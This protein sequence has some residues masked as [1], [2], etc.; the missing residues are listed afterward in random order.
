MSLRHPRTVALSLCTVAVVAVGAWRYVFHR[1]VPTYVVVLDA[2]E[3][4]SHRCDAVLGVVDQFVHRAEQSGAHL[5]LVRT[6]DDKTADEPVQYFDAGLTRQIRRV[7]EGEASARER[8]DATRRALLDEVRRRCDQQP[9]TQ[10]SPV[11]LAAARAVAQVASAPHPEVAVISDLEENAE[12][13]IRRALR[14]GKPLQVEAITMIDNANVKVMFCGVAATTGTVV[15]TSGSV[16]RLTPN[17]KAKEL[18]WSERV[19]R[20]TFTSPGDVS[21]VPFCPMA[22]HTAVKLAQR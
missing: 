7:M 21:F 18:A 16:R 19:W 2:S 10:R 13:V 8:T 22:P 9:V 4:P 14:G 3:S 1:D 12:E 11:Y 5:L 15:T 17:R 6:G 20:S